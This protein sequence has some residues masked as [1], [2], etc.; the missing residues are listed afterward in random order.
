MGN[1][2]GESLENDIHPLEISINNA[3]SQPN[4]EK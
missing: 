4:Y 2:E 3:T 1:D